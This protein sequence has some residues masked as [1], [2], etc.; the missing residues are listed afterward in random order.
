MAKIL[1]RQKRLNNTKKNCERRIRPTQLLRCTVARIACGVYAASWY[2]ILH[3][4]G[5]CARHAECALRL[6]VHC[7]LGVNKNGALMHMHIHNRWVCVCV[8]L[9]MYMAHSI[10]PGTQGR[11]VAT[12]VSGTQGGW[13]WRAFRNADYAAHLQL[14]LVL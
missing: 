8:Y 4:S 7:P 6:A 3:A 1:G 13:V 2:G 12:H 10:V 11:H 5:D 9:N 14:R